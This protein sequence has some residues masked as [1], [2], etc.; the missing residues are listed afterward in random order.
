MRFMLLF[1]CAV[2]AQ[3]EPGEQWITKVDETNFESVV[4]N[5]Q[6]DVLLVIKTP[7]AHR[8]SLF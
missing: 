1:F 8:T 2:M 6:K 4:M 7:G 3:P 5:P